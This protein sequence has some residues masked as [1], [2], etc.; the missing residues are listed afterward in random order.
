VLPPGQLSAEFFAAVLS[1]GGGFYRAF[2]YVAEAMRQGITVLPP[3]VNASALRA[4]GKGK[5]I[6]IG[7]EFVRGCRLTVSAG[8]SDGRTVRRSGSL[9]EAW[10]T[11][12]N[13]PVSRTTLRTLIRVGACDSIANARPAD[14]ALE[15]DRQPT[16]PVDDLLTVRPSDRPTVLRDYTAARKRERSTAPSASPPP[17]T[18]CSST[19]RRSAAPDHPATELH[20]HVGKRVLCAGLLTT[21]KPVTTVQDEPMEFA[22]FDDGTGLI[23]TVLFRASTRPGRTSSSIRG[24]SSS[25]ARWRRSSGG[26]GDGHRP[27]AAG[28]DG[29]EAGRAR[30]RVTR[31]VS[32]PAPVARRPA[33]RGGRCAPVERP[34]QPANEIRRRRHGTTAARRP[35]PEPPPGPGAGSGSRPPS[36]PGSGAK[37]LA[38][39]DFLLR[40]HGADQLVL[41]LEH[42]GWHGRKL[43]RPPT[44]ATA[45]SPGPAARRPGG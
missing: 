19:R 25:A 20:R 18:R 9:T 38:G 30:R 31:G 3:D 34:E 41:F 33:V 43:P 11:F 28:A 8:R 15:L 22:T 24:R 45:P 39:T 5:E 4:T 42:A 16:V 37:G 21:A 7:L 44:P 27:G 2:A 32:R 40:T 17:A 13:G 36:S 10:K 14:A 35:E 6:R 23:E 26:D 29:G 12:G 1:N